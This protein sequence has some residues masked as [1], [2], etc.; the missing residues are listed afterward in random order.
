MTTKPLTAREAR[1]VDSYR[2]HGKAAQ[3]AREAGY[4]ARR[5]HKIG[6]RVLRRP[7]IIAALREHGIEIVVPP[8]QPGNPRPYRHVCKRNGLTLLQERFV[9]QYLIDGNAS[10]AA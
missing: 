7:K 8:K 4:S 10:Q 2:L 6:G 1:F 3:A 5:A 9:Y